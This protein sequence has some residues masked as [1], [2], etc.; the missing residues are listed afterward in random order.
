M[1]TLYELKIALFLFVGL[2]PMLFSCASGDSES[3]DQSS[4]DMQDNVIIDTLTFDEGFW[5]PGHIRIYWVDTNFNDSY[6]LNE[7]VE[8]RTTWKG[9]YI[10]LLSH[11]EVFME[12]PDTNV[13]IRNVNDT[14]FFVKVKPT[15]Q[16][17]QYINNRNLLS[18]D[19]A[20]RPHK[21][22][23]FDAYWL[24]E[25]ISHPQSTR[26]LELTRRINWKE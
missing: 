10:G 22:Y 12:S 11:C 9:E 26:I 19:P 21:G 3:V 17:R 24:D 18:I 1:K 25:P 15:Y 2:A 8:W 13:L 20:I 16:G 6:P 23:I 5:K 4:L 7:W 14:T